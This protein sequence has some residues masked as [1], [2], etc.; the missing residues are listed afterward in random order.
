LQAN[1]YD[2]ISRCQRSLCTH[3]FR[4][5]NYKKAREAWDDWFR[6]Y[7]PPRSEDAI[8]YVRGLKQRNIPFKVQLKI[9]FWDKDILK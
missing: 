7:K 4:Q 3:F 9:A 6:E 8:E 2:A 5:G 1:C